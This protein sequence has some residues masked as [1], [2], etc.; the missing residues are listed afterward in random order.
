[1]F[2]SQHDN[3]DNKLNANELA[4]AYLEEKYGETFY[5]SAPYGDSMTGTRSLLATCNSFP[6]QHIVVQIENF[7]GDDKVFRDNYLAVKYQAETIDFLRSCVSDVYPNNN[8]YYNVS[9]TCQSANLSADSSFEEYLAD[10]RAELIMMLELKA[11]EFTGTE[12][13]NDII[14]RITESCNHMTLTVVVVD[15]SIFGTLDRAGLNKRISHRDYVA[16]ATVYIDSD[17]VK[18][19][20]RGEDKPNE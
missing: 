15:D 19:D 18:I 12:P 20:W 6:D 9:K 16:Q 5:F 7:K 2:N 14:S 3:K 10:G 13:F 8:I 4:L 11:S 17:G 1:M